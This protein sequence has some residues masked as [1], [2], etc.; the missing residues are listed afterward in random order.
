MVVWILGIKN[1]KKIKLIK[2]LEWLEVGIVVQ[3][4]R[5][6]KRGRVESLDNDRQPLE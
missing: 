6:T 4:K 1:N 2:Q 5:I 3:N